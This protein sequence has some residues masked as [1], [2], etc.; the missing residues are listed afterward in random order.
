MFSRN[1]KRLREEKGLTKAELSRKT[2][3][4]ARTIEYLENEK[5]GNPTL[6]TLEILSEVF[7]VGVEELIK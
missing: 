6:K 2:G 3:L 7:G 4:S 1:L 5:M